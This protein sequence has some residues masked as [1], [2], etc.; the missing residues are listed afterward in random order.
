MPIRLPDTIKSL[1]P[2]VPGK[3]IEEVQREFGLTDIVKLASNE[4]PLG[5]PPLAMA[6]IV[7]YARFSALYP[8]AGCVELKQAISE[9]RG[10]PVLSLCV[11]NGSDE[12]IHFL[13]QLL[14][15]A[16]DNI[17]MADPGFSRY[18][19][20]ATAAG[21]ETRKVPLDSDDKHDL[22]S[23]AAAVDERTRIMWVANPNNPTGTIVRRAELGAFLENLPDHVAVVLDEAYFEFA[24]DDEYPKSTDYITPDGNILGLR[25]FSKTYG[26]ASLR[27]GYAIGPDRIIDALERIREPFNVNAIAQKAAIAALK[28]QDHLSRTIELNA[29]GIRR[30]TEFLTSKGFKVS[31][32]FA[33]FVWCDYGSPSEWI[34]QGLL[35]RGV[36][37]RPGSVFGCPNHLRISVGTDEELNRFESALTSVLGQT[38]TV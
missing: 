37:V 3:P 15:E 6:A 28:D 35:Q 34:A 1:R 21:A 30:L 4:N 36:I 2:Y 12:M 23:M 25:T 33:N 18:E 31:E 22:Q 19:S 24:T 11:G 9:A 26:L 17:V 5:P 13:S 14:L 27:V 16:G 8:D 38:A 29:S 7:D 10:I 32:S 20:E